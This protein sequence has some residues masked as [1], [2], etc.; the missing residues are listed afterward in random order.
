MES[1]PELSEER[2]IVIVSPDDKLDIQE[3]YF[4]SAQ[5]KIP[6][7]G[8]VNLLGSRENEFTRGQAG[9]TIAENRIVLTRANELDGMG[10]LSFGWS[11]MVCHRKITC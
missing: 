2:G 3:D 1:S 11:C 6:D 5:V 9:I 8:N 4:S 10:L 7:L